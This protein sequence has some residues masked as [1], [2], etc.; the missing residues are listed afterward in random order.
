[1]GGKLSAKD[2]GSPAQR[3]LK[4]TVPEWRFQMQR[5]ESELRSVSMC[6]Y[7]SWTQ[8]EGVLTR[9]ALVPAAHCP[10]HRPLGFF[11]LSHLSLILPLS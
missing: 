6:Q 9:K 8:A 2:W 10:S 1:M 11:E 4:H 7:P 5:L 3:N